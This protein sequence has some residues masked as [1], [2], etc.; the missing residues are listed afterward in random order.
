MSSISTINGAAFL[1][2][3]PT[4]GN[5]MLDATS[6]DTADWMD[7]SSNGP[8]YVGIAANAFAKAHMVNTTVNGQLA[9]NQGIATMQSLLAPSGAGQLVNLFA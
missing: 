7:P 5:W 6:T 8:D 3:V 1:Q 9:V 2:S 4:T